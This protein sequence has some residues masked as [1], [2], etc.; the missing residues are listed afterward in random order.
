[1]DPPHHYRHATDHG[2]V[3]PRERR[4]HRADSRKSCGNTASSADREVGRERERD[5][6]DRDGRSDRE[7]RSEPEDRENRARAPREATNPSV[8]DFEDLRRHIEDATSLSNPPGPSHRGN[9]CFSDSST[10]KS[11]KSI[12]SSKEEHRD[13]GERRDN[14]PT[15]ATK[16]SADISSRESDISRRDD[17]SRNNNFIKIFLRQDFYYFRSSFIQKCM[18]VSKYK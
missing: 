3:D 10:T 15:A 7:G 5:R 13:R 6:S 4:H 1:M 12:P 18:E 17:G 11:N 14:M 8:D 2:N 16:S 9:R